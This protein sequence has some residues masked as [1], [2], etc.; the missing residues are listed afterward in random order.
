MPQKISRLIELEDR[1]RTGAAF[2]L[3]VLERLL[4]VGKRRGGTVDDPDVIIGIDPD[5]DRR[6]QHPVVRKGLWPQRIDF[7]AGRHVARRLRR[8][9]FV[10]RRLAKRKRAKECGK[11]GADKEISRACQIGQFAQ[12]SLPYLGASVSPDAMRRKGLKGARSS[13]YR[14]FPARFLEGKSGKP[15]RDSEVRLVGHAGRET[16]KEPRSS[17]IDSFSPRLGGRQ[18]ETH[19]PD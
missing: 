13:A 2:A 16:E 10:E 4:V 17:A 3:I 1:R 7:E 19:A 14:R 18:Q 8:D 11:A 12:M 5:A 15:E 6:A 9:T